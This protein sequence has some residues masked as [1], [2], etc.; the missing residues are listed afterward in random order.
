M[1]NRV[2]QISSKRLSAWLPRREVVHI[3]QNLRLRRRPTLIIFAQIDRP[4]NALQLYRQRFSHKE[5]LQQTFFKRGA[6]ID[7][8]RS[9][10]VVEPLCDA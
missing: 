8:K 5:A 3:M 7:G 9:F 10:C 6:V 2:R 1:K 4:I